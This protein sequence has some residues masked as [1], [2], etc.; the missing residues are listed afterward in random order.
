MVDPLLATG[1]SFHNPGGFHFKSRGVQ[2]FDFLG[3]AVD[4]AQGAVKVLQVHDHDVVPQA[5]ALQ[6]AHQVAVDDGELTRQVGLDRQIA[7]A[8]LDTGVHA[9]DVGDGGGRCNGHAVGIAHAVFGNLLAQSIPVHGA[10]AV[11]F[12]IAA[13]LF[14]EHVKGVQRHD[15][16]IPQGAFVA[17]V[18]AALGSQLG[19]R[20]VSVVADG[21][22]GR[23]GKF[24]SLLGGIRHALLVER[25]LETHETQAHRTVTHIRVACFFDGVV[26]D[27]DHVVEHAHGRF[28]GALQFGVV[29]LFAVG[30]VHQVLWQVDRT[31][32]AHRSFGVAGVQSDLGAQV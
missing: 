30:A 5:Q 2:G 4:G 6:V 32:V 23:V 16:L 21:F 8:W 22:H 9:N 31:Q 28:D 17:G 13:A 14:L 10:A 18:L 7:K 12:H 1:G 15:A 25:I 3:H 26:V 20:P 27:V 19:G 11:N 24:H 29:D